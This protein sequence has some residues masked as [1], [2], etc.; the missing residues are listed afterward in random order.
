MEFSNQTGILTTVVPRALARNITWLYGM[1]GVNALFPLILLPYLVRVLGPEEWG[2]VSFTQAF[3]GYLVVI[4]EF[5]F[6]LSATRAVAQDREKPENLAEL[7]AGVLGAKLLLACGSLVVALLAQLWVAH[8]REHPILFW[9]GVFAALMQSFSL[10]WF[11][12]GLE[13]MRVV[14]LAEILTK[15]GVFC[16]V[17]VFVRSWEDGWRVL[18]LQGIGAMLSFVFTLALIYREIPVR[19]PSFRTVWGTIQMG[20]SLFVFQAAVSLYTVGNA[21]L[22]GLFAPPQIVGY[23]AGAEKISKAFLVLLDPIARSLYPRMSYLAPIARGEAARVIRIAMAYVGGA[24]LVMG[25]LLFLLAPLFVS[26]ILGEAFEP[27]VP[28]VR[29]LWLLI[30]LIAMSN[31]LGILWMLPLGLDRPFNCIIVMA[32]LLNVGLAVALAP[33]YA[34]VG[35]AWAVVMAEAFVTVGICLVLYRRNESPF[36]M[37]SAKGSEVI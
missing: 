19:L 4:G 1:Q 12:Q 11:F 13:R 22:L 25:L 26:L 16:G 29:I 10:V 34:H 7:V 2:L 9:S 17:L 5:G 33:H 36:K 28:V 30:P 23:Y 6:A 32:G 14:A 3:A 27:A 31:V 8:F 15:F 20:W 21:F 24:S 37:A 18:A 35:V